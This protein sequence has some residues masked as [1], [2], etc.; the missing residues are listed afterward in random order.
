MFEIISLHVIQTFICKR[1][2]LIDVLLCPQGEVDA[3]APLSEDRQHE[4]DLD[5]LLPSF[6]LL[7]T[8]Q[9]NEQT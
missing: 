5:A 9:C 7:A 2:E 8:K 4:H 3:N 1:L 6:V